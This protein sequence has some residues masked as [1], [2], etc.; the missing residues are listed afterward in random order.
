MAAQTILLQLIS[1]CFTKVESSLFFAIYLD[2]EVRVETAHHGSSSS[3]SQKVN[4]GLSPPNIHVLLAGFSQRHTNM[5]SGPSPAS[6][7]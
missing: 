5:T 4:V 7:S 1:K 2:T 3:R 6:D